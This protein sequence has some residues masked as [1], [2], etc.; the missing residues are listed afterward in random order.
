MNEAARLPAA[1]AYIP[2]IGWVFVLLFQRKN[3]LAVFHVRQSIGLVLFLIAALVVW[4]VIA[5]LLVWI[6]FGGV[7]GAA[8]F[9]LVM[10]AYF[11][12]FV[13]LIMGIINALR[14]RSTPLPGF[15][16]WAN[17]LPIR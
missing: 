14:N 4:A 6:P 3:P 12:G 5:W 8:F 16:Q 2:V 10:V 1:L 17:R 15:G 9:T 7:V 11:Y 13:A